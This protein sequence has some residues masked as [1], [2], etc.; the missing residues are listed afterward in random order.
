[1]YNAI[2]CVKIN[3]CVMHWNL[4]CIWLI[5][6]I[7]ILVFFPTLIYQYFVLT[8]QTHLMMVDSMQFNFIQ[9]QGFTKYKQR[10]IINS[11]ALFEPRKLLR[12]RIQNNQELLY[13]ISSFC[14]QP[15]LRNI[16]IIIS[17]IK[18]K[19]HSSTRMEKVQ[20]SCFETP[21]VTRQVS[22]KR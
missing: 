12:M 7:L 4:H 11:F 2:S 13:Y 6:L 9:F 18:P 14:F 17:T 8:Q 3:L 15:F 16:S 5:F 21:H 19:L 22:V 20:F 1:M 10:F